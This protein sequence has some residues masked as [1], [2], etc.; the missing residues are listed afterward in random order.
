M[1]YRDKYTPTDIKVIFI[2]E[3]PPEGH[4]FVYDP[5]GHTGEVLFRTFMKLIGLAPKTKEEGLEALKQK[6]ILLINPTYVPVNKLKD[7]EA[8][9]IIMGNY[10][11]F[12]DDLLVHNPKKQIPLILVKANICRLLNDP[13]KKDGFAVLNDGVMIPFPVHY[14]QERFHK[15]VSEM[16]KGII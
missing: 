16:I 15:L 6:G 3:S 10:D 12:V 11:N 5:N 8:D 4:G 9:K 1:E 7:T 2:L 14:H 13:L